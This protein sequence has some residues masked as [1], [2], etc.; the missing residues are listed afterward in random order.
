MAISRLCTVREIVIVHGQHASQ[1]KRQPNI[2]IKCQNP[3]V[4][5]N[6][7]ITGWRIVMVPITL[8]PR[9]P[10]TF[11]NV[12][13][14]N[15]TTETTMAHSNNMWIAPDAFTHSL[16][17]KV[18]E[19]Q[20]Q[21]EVDVY[22]LDQEPI[23]SRVHRCFRAELVRTDSPHLFWKYLQNHWRAQSIQES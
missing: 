1:K 7:P 23:V 18:H 9:L 12:W 21:F 20:H 2:A 13:V 5:T 16:L 8:P 3:I 15:T 6:S 14:S 19:V 17:L 4:L 11:G 22:C 10:A